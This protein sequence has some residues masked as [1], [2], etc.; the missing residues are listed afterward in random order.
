MQREM[1]KSIVVEQAQR[2][3]LPDDAIRR[4]AEARLQDWRETPFIVCVTGLRR[5]GKSTL[6][7]QLLDGG[8]QPVYF[9][10]FDDERLMS[11]DTSDFQ[12][13]NEVF[14]ELYGEEGVYFFDEIQNVEG[15]ECFVR[16]LHEAGRKVYVTGSN[17]SMLSSEFGTRLTGR[18]LQLELFPFSFR[19]YVDYKRVPA[20]P[21]ALHTT[22]GRARIRSAFMQ[23][24]TEG[25]IPEF[26]STGKEYFLQSLYDNI[27]YRD[28]ISGHLIRKERQF[29]ELVHYLMSNCGKEHS[30]NALRKLVGLSNAGTIKEYIACLSGSYLL[31]SVNQ[32]EPS[33]IQQMKAPKKVYSIDCALARHVSFAFSENMGRQ[34]ENVVY[35]HLRRTGHEIYHHHGD[36]NCDFLAVDRG[37][38]AAAIQV[39]A[40][41]ESRETRAR[42]LRGLRDAMREYGLR[43]GVIVTLDDE[44]QVKEGRS[45][46]EIV[47]IWKWLWNQSGG[48]ENL[49][50]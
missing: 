1:L 47:P 8:H 6:V 4:E 35:L 49:L 42:E 3:Y 11:F 12:M 43:R 16:R 26:I 5:A 45:T 7:H 46:V 21:D 20:A 38:V 34:V 9:L 24:L 40:D 13:L 50:P 41:M 39:C 25:G 36:G 44:E 27:I 33:L 15:W 48:A 30:H 2:N 23:Y 28:I 14:Y 29:K 37:K 19:E 10:N 22:A 32:F 17:A 18:H 31:E